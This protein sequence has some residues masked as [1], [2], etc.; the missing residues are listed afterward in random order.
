[1][2]AR[3]VLAFPTLQ[4]FG[5]YEYNPIT[6]EEAQRWLYQGPYYSAIRSR[7]LCRAFYHVTGK[8]L[9]PLSDMQT[10]VLAPGE[11]ALV[12]SVPTSD[13]VPSLREMSV[14]Y[15]AAHYQLGLLKRVDGV[16]QEVEATE[17]ESTETV[18]TK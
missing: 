16:A 8:T 14:E 2:T 9:Y 1:M 15:M 17:V 7:D 18:S 13:S 4:D 11:D 6:L 12:F 3:F 5:C 10:P